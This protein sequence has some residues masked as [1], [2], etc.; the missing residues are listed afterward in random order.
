VPIRQYLIVI[1]TALVL[2]VLQTT[3]LH[4]TAQTVQIDLL[5][6]LVV[7]LGLFKD[8]VHGAAAS[9]LIGYFEDLFATEVTGLFMTARLLVFIAAQFLKVRL[10]P[11]KPMAQFVI[12]LVLGALDRVVVTTLQVI[13]SDA[14]AVLSFRTLVLL[15]IGT[16]LNAA[17]VPLVYLLLRLAPGFVEAPR[18]PRILE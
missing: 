5:F 1:P 14:P 17:L 9:C 18:G 3:I 2:I 13:F 12:A 10:S 7:I 15:L 6:V 11:D 4:F 8:P 16:V